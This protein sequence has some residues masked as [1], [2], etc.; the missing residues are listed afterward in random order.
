[1]FFARSMVR[2]V[3]DV[4]VKKST[5]IKNLKL[6]KTSPSSFNYNQEHDKQVYMPPRNFQNSSV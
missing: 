2:S 4:F 3:R 6:F 5:V 1:M